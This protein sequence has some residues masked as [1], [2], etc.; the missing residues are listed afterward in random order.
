MDIVVMPFTINKVTNW[1]R[2]VTLGQADKVLAPEVNKKPGRM[3]M[4]EE[5]K[6]GHE[7]GVEK[8]SQERADKQG[9]VGTNAPAP[10]RD[11]GEDV[12]IGGKQ[13]DKK[14]E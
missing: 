4:A 13:E 11:A 10:S 9:P 14:N 12:K 6:M 2:V 7:T 5:K 3:K 8:V 1:P